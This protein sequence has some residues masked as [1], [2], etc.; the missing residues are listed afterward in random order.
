MDKNT[1]W[2]IIETAKNKSGTNMELRYNTLVSLLVKYEP[3]DIIKFGKM[4]SIYVQAAEENYAVWAA[5]KVIE[6]YA[7]DDTFLYFCCWLVSQG[8]KTYTQAVK[9]P[10][11]LA[12]RETAKQ[13]DHTFEM[14]MAVAFEAYGQKTGKPYDETA[15]NTGVAEVEAAPLLENIEF[16]DDTPFRQDELEAKRQ[17]PLLLPKLTAMFTYDAK[18]NIIDMEKLLQNPDPE[19][20]LDGMRKTLIESGVDISKLPELAPQPPKPASADKY[21]KMNRYYNGLA[22]V[23]KDGKWGFIN[24]NGNEIIPLIYDMACN[25]TYGDIVVVELDGKMGYVHKSGKVVVE[26]KYDEA[27][28][29]GDDE[30]AWVELNGKKGFINQEGQEVVPL[31]YE[32]LEFGEE[33]IKGRIGDKWETIDFES[34]KK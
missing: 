8:S 24:V 10:E 14:L 23:Q 12:N 5:C 31:I 29:F 4:A 21:D 22:A 26:P 3:D 19:A 17:I 30:Y 18:T 32:E 25:F 15:E 20:A 28:L 6:G 16:V 27:T 7:S 13:E 9:N 34:I 11:S 1:F 2:K 33:E